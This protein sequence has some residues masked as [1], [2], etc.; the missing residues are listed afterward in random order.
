MARR[1]ILVV[2]D[3]TRLRTLWMEALSEAGYATVGAEDGITALELIRDLFPD[4]ILLDLRMPRLSGR[5]FLD[6]V[7]QHRR[8]SQIPILIV[9][10]F[11]DDEARPETEHG[12][13]IVGRMQKP[14]RL[15]ELI[16]AVRSTIGPSGDGG[17]R[18]SILSP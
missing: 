4:L 15:A 12:L 8:W 13:R 10:A 16:E 11:L 3:D 18:A 9:S 14:V 6:S 1:W 17:G 5:G 7:R 2:D